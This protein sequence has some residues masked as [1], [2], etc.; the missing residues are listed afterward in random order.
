MNELL[1]L[2]RSIDRTLRKLSEE[3]CDCADG[4]RVD[5]DEHP[6]WCKYRQMFEA[7]AGAVQSVCGCFERS[8]K[9]VATLG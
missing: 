8:K 5:P 6:E 4:H 7:D 2:Y 1:K 3:C 9:K